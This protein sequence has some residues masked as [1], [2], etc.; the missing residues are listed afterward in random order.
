MLQLLPQFFLERR[1]LMDLFAAVCLLVL[2]LVLVL[3][4]EKALA[5]KTVKTTGQDLPQHQNSYWKFEGPKLQKRVLDLEMEL[6]QL[7][8]KT[9]WKQD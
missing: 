7:R 3:V 1:L 6:E 8:S 5:Q 9:L 4:L 2:G